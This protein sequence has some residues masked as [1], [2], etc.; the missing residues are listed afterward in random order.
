MIAFRSE[1]DGYDTLDTP[2]LPYGGLRSLTAEP[3]KNAIKTALETYL[4]GSLQIADNNP[5]LDGPIGL[6]VPQSYR[7]ASVSDYR[8]EQ[9]WPSVVITSHGLGPTEPG[10]QKQAGKWRVSISVV[11]MLQEQ[12]DTKLAIMLDRYGD[13]LWRALQQV[14][15]YA[16]WRLDLPSASILPS[17]VPQNNAA[18]RGV[19]VFIEGSSY[20]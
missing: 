1:Q 19:G 16:G 15:S 6:P 7:L 14:E 8:L 4:P 17:E 18:F 3:L 20:G 5:D 11:A 12:D 13:A 10:E 9:V 2:I